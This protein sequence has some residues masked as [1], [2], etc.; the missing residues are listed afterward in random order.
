MSL[1]NRKKAG[2]AH[3]AN[4]AVMERHKIISLLHP[5]ELRFFNKFYVS[6]YH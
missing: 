3:I 4:E 5:S 6:I 2:R 1:R